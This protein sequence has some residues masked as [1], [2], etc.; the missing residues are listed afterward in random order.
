MLLSRVFRPMAL[1]GQQWLSTSASSPLKNRLAELIPAKQEQV[2]KIK[3]EYGNVVID[4]VTVDQAYGGARDVSCLV[5]ETSL[6]DAQEGIRMRGHTIF[7]LQERL[8]R[9]CFL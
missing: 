2:N 5:C 8:P 1:S 6:L 4:T 7:D 9:V 3:K